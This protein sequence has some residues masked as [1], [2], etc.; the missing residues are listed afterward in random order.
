MFLKNSFDSVIPELQLT[1]EDYKLVANVNK[2]LTAYIE[3]LD[4]MK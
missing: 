3:H 4:K 1:E 2:D